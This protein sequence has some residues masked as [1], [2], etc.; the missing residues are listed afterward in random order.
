VHE[1]LSGLDRIGLSFEVRRDH[2]AQEVADILSSGVIAHFG[3]NDAPA[4]KIVDELSTSPPW[5]SCAAWVCPAGRCT[6]LPGS[7]TRGGRSRG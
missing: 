7:S 2:S 5:S 6:A 4:I 3:P 1:V